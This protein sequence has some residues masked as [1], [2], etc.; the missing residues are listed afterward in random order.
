MSVINIH[1]D[2]TFNTKVDSK[3]NEY[4]FE[5]RRTILPDNQVV[6]SASPLAILSAVP[7]GQTPSLNELYKNYPLPGEA[8]MFDIIQT[9]VERTRNFA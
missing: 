9:T 4:M 1:F 7:P 6:S 5:L 8:L 2:G 3:I